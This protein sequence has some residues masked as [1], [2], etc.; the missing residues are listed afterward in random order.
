MEASFVSALADMAVS[1]CIRI[2]AV[3]VLLIAGNI[4]IRILLNMLGRSK[5]FDRADSSVRTFTLSAV[6]A[7]FYVM[8]FVSAIGIL[9]VP[10]T[11]VFAALASVGVTIGLALQGALSNLAGG[12]M[13][14]VF[15]PF[16]TGDFI[17]AADVS[18]TVQEIRMFYTII[19]SIDN[20]RITVPNGNLMN[21]NIVDYSWKKQRRVDMMFDCARSENPA[22]VQEI[23][24]QVLAGDPRIL[25]EPQP[26]FARLY[27]A[28]GET[29][30][31]AVRVWCRNEDYWDLYFDLTQRIT[32][33]LADA[34]IRLPEMRM[35]VEDAEKN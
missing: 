16:R 31:F 35:R 3:V 26:P 5:I 19:V 28:A 9:G 33:A 12:I 34:G 24:D 7:I 10:M 30:Q 1:A 8:L 2:V 18:G 29:L 22:R 17:E 20:K 4:V 21:T 11:S 15:R 23:I 27:S 14:M 25:Q 32:E 6:R 13:L